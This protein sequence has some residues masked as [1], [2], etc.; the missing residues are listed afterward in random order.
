LEGDR[1]KTKRKIMLNLF[2][3]YQYDV[4]FSFGNDNLGIAESIA[5]AF[6][7][8]Q[9]KYFL[10]TEHTPENAGRPLID[11]T[12]EV[13]A[14]GLSRYVL[15]IR[16]EHFAKSF[17]SRVEHLVAEK[18]GR[19]KNVYIIKLML[20][21]EAVD[22]DSRDVI[23]LKWNG[24]PHETAIMIAVKLA[25]L[26]KERKKR[27][28]FFS[29][30]FMVSLLTSAAL[31]PYVNDAG[32]A[33]HS[34]TGSFK[35]GKE[36]ATEKKTE[37]TLIRTPA[38]ISGKTPVALKSSKGTDAGGILPIVSKPPAFSPAANS[39]KAGFSFI[40]SI[41][42]ARYSSSIH[43]LQF[44]FDENNMVNIF[45][46]VHIDDITAKARLKNNVLVIAS[47]NITGSL[48]LLDSARSVTGSIAIKET[49]EKMNIDFKRE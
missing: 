29:V 18:Y 40:Q 28:F 2:R 4:A 19:N 12:M 14:G 15:E 30:V 26:E 22:Q 38:N 25:M 27:R 1:K 9:V 17:W 10:Y 8:L 44:T 33:G 20:N 24:N 11:V 45:G 23:Y 36:I 34:V 16:D 21:N 3:S 31:L 46:R 39:S 5:K 7:T 49:G 13:Y 42:G 35:T 41:N 47:G 43:Y 48:S 6:A 32:T 37:T